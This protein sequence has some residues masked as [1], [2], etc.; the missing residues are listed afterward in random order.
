MEFVSFEKEYPKEFTSLLI[1]QENGDIVRGYYVAWSNIVYLAV[2]SNKSQ[3][4][5]WK[6]FN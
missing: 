4:T 2:G 6:Y 1:K 5:E 3:A